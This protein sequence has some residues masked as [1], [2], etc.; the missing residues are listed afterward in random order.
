MKIQTIMCPQTVLAEEKVDPVFLSDEVYRRRKQLLD[1][2]IRQLD[3]DYIIMYGDR[4]HFANIEYFTK[5]DCRFEEALFIVRKDGT[6]WIVVGNEGMP[7]SAIVPFEINRF[8]YGNFSLQG[9]P[10]YKTPVL[11]QLFREIGINNHSKVGIAGYKYYECGVDVVPEKCF[12]IPTYI[13]QSIENVTGCENIS[14]F[15]RELTSLPDGLRM[16]I[17][18]A[19]EIAFIEYQAVVA[20]NTMRRLISGVKEGMSEIELSANACADLRPNMAFANILVGEQSVRLGLK[21]P[22]DF[23]RLKD[24]NPMTLSFSTRGSMCARSGVAAYGYESL[25]EQQKEKF[26]HLYKNYW[27]AIAAWYATIGIGTKGRV[28]YSVVAEYIGA[29]EFGLGLNPG[30]SIGMDE[31][32]NSPV[33]IDSEIAIHSG[34]HIQCDI[35]ASCSSPMMNAICEDTV[36]IA[37]VSLREQLH[38]QF[39]EVYDRIIARQSFMR[40][41]LNI[42]IKD[43]VLL[44]SGLNAIMFPFMLSRK[45]IY[46]L[47]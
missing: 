15:N 16:K 22:D 35:I 21:S 20:A 45:E 34:T 5:Y 11:S 29:P 40:N 17:R 12:D 10:R 14:D 28:L 38:F 9:Q 4:E 39:P 47:A 30:Y 7:Y 41:V 36:V 8:Y 3:M 46:A 43:E 44:M 13:Y 37:D 24:G 33:S 2:R 23:S 1:A 18:S 19:N 6:S 27:K 32:T 31:W 26:D 42:P 25:S